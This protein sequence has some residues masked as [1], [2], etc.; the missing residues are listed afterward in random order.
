MTATTFLRIATI[1]ALL[2]FVAHTSLVVF[3]SPKHGPEEVSV[4]QA[5]KS[6]RFDQADERCLQGIAEVRVPVTALGP[7]E[8]EA[9]RLHGLNHRHFFGTVLWRAEDYERGVGHELK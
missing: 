7:E 9:M 4:I 6:D 5:M 3:S 1:V 2:Q 8:V